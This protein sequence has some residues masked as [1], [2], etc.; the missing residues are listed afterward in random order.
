MVLFVGLFVCL[1]VGWFVCL[2]LFEPL[3]PSSFSVVFLRGIYTVN[4]SCSAVSAGLTLEGVLGF[5]GVTPQEN[6]WP[7]ADVAS[8]HE[9]QEMFDKGE[10]VT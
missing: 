3:D 5:K 7:G 10:G 8:P 1:F 4:C 9:G 6:L 2:F